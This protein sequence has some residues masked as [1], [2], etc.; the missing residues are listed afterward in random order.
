LL[1]QSGQYSINDSVP[2]L[3]D[4]IE[5]QTEAAEATALAKRTTEYRKDTVTF[6]KALEIRDTKQESEWASDQYKFMNQFKEASDASRPCKDPS[7][8]EWLECWKEEEE[9]QAAF[10]VETPWCPFHVS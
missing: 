7:I 1:V 2:H 3:H 4:K 8:N 6:E 5:K 10:S 9:R